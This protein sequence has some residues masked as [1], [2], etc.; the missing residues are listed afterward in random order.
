[1]KALISRAAGLLLAIVAAGSV[2]VACSPG[3]RSPGE[4]ADG[5]ETIYVGDIVTVNDAQ[6]AAEAV[7]VKDGRILAVGSADEVM[8]HRGS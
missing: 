5:A 7:A 1:M 6:P 8:A 4:S 3:E 2:S